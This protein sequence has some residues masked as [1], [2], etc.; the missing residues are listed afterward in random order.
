VPG[1]AGAARPPS[2]PTVAVPRASLVTAT[3]PALPA[4]IGAG[5][6]AGR[7]RIVSKLGEGGMGEVFRADDLALGVSVAL[8]FLP[9]ALAADQAWLDRFRAEVRLARQITHPNICR[10]YDIG[11]ADGRTFLSM[12]YVDGEDL[13]SVMKRFGRLAP[14]RAVQISRQ[15]CLGLAAAHDQGVIHRDLKP[16]NIM[17][18]GRGN[19]KLMDFG[20]AGLASELATTAN[21]V[22]GTPA[23][24]APE[25]LAGE[26]VSKRSDLYSLGLVLYELFTGVE[27]FKDEDRR[28]LDAVRRALKE[29][30][31]PTRP[32]EIVRDIDPKVEAVILQC[33]EADPARRPVST[34]AVAAALPGG[35]PLAE[36]LAAG[37]TPSPELVARAG[38]TGRLPWRIAVAL[39]VAV[40]GAVIIGG[41]VADRVGVHRHARLELPPEVLAAKAREMTRTLMGAAA[42]AD[43]LDGSWDSA[44][45]LD[46]DNGAIEWL[47]RGQSSRAATLERI[48][49]S[50]PPVVQFWFRTQP[51]PLVPREWWASR[52]LVADPPR[53]APGSIFVITDSRGVLQRFDRIPPSSGVAKVP[54]ISGEGPGAWETFFRAAHLDPGEFTPI[55]PEWSPVT[56]PA[57]ARAAWSGPDPDLPGETIIVEASSLA[58]APASFRVLRVWSGVLAAAKGLPA[59][60]ATA[61][62]DNLLQ[63]FFLSGIIAAPA[64]AVFNLRRRRGDRRA[65]TIFAIGILLVDWLSRVMPTHSINDLLANV[66]QSRPQARALWTAALVYFAYIGAEPFVRRLWPQLLI[67]WS[68]FIAGEWKD[69]M[70][71]RDVLSG[72]AAGAGMFMFLAA[73]RAFEFVPP[74]S[75]AQL[76]WPDLTVTLGERFLAA[77]LL[78]FISGAALSAMLLTL[79]LVGLRILVRVQI[80]ASLLLAVFMLPALAGLMLSTLAGFMVASCYAAVAAF[81]FTR[82]GVLA[83]IAMF[84]TWNLL[85]TAPTGTDLS[86]WYAGP[87]VVVSGSLLALASVCAWRCAKRKSTP[88]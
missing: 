72:M 28:T 82:I 50:Q 67:G 38:G 49:A 60:G 36:A 27:P 80:V 51:T 14:E 66:I 85:Q 12:E 47:G 22:C 46:V 10:V 48:R 77:Q 65:A 69:A 44:W 83:A 56:V 58:G 87:A 23:Y 75:G 21:I 4:G 68:R 52:V 54:V 61:W 37:Q 24:M 57:D 16:A 63:L 33:L 73:A 30:V 81:V 45:G 18:D 59:T 76:W 6:L 35:D 74:E 32:L 64:M 8:K 71:S 11:Q 26:A 31:Q 88:P 17:I 15:L 34:I 86:A 13:A 3:E 84:I 29:G 41:L 78:G 55:D 40:I 7:Y 2:G 39:L 70:V 53:T 20:V 43:F 25:Q 5:L 19:A 42:E 1:A 79:L 62:R 9:D